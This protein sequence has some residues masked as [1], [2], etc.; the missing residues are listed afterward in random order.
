M[1]AAI[2]KPPGLLIVVSGPA[3]SGKTTLSQRILLEEPNLSRVVTSTT[4]KP[5]KGEKDGIDYHFLDHT[6]FEEKIEAGEFYE[7]ARVH[8]KLY[9]TLKREVREKLATGMDLL[10]I[11]DVQGAD[12]LREKALTDELLKSRLATIFILPPSIKEL[13]KRLRE[14]AT[15]GDDEIRKRL[16]VAIE[17]MRQSNRY[18]YC[19]RSGSRKEDFR[20]LQAIYHAEKMRN[21]SI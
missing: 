6:I 2:P 11:I 19:L 18:D 15:D 12:S 17:E 10:L 20:N 16:K 4:R 8:G 5:R 3:G 1:D 13:E 9:G 21:R 14:R 7:Y